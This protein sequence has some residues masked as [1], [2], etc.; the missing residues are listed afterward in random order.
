MLKSVLNY[1]LQME[2]IQKLVKLD[3]LW[4][5]L[6]RSQL[7]WMQVYHHVNMP[8]ML[9]KL[10]LLLDQLNP[11]V[12]VIRKWQTYDCQISKHSWSSPYSCKV[13][14]TISKVNWS[15]VRKWIAKYHKKL[16]TAGNNKIPISIGEKWGRPL[17]LPVKLDA[18]LKKFIVCLCEAGGNINCH[19]IHRVLMGLIKVDLLKYGSCLDF[20]V[21]REWI[22]LKDNFLL[23]NF[24]RVFPCLTTKATRVTKKN[25][26][27][28]WRRSS[29]LTW[30]R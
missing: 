7:F 19:V 18:K 13:C 15:T 8:S 10:L 4:K 26:W 25:H 16:S 17:S 30:K 23:W 1:L 28:D 20:N 12:S 21:T 6:N 22:N 14:E 3:K 9:K 29:T 2:T 5:Y 24:R 27:R 11:N